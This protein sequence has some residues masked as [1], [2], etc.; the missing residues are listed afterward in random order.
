MLNF[1]DPEN[2]IPLARMV[3]RRYRGL[4]WQ[5][6]QDMI[7]HVLLALT[8]YVKRQPGPHPKS[9]WE[10]VA[11]LAAVEWYRE[12]LVRKRPF[13]F[14]STAEHHA[15]S[16]YTPKDPVADFMDRISPLNP[17]A[18]HQLVAYFVYGMGPKEYAKVWGRQLQTVW[19]KWQRTKKRVVEELDFSDVSGV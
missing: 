1:N 6:R 15:K 5:D 3:T 16:G 9:H 2:W 12:V 19:H 11:S 10:R 13:P 17:A 14:S 18:Q 8:K 4:Q 7:G